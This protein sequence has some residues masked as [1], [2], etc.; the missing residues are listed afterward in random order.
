MDLQPFPEIA[1]L[2]ANATTSVIMAIDFND[3]TQPAEFVIV[4]NS[5]S[6][7]VKVSAPVGE[8]LQPNTITEKDFISRKSKTRLLTFHSVHQSYNTTFLDKLGG[9]NEN[10]ALVKVSESPEQAIAKAIQLSSNVLQVSASEL[11]VFYFAGKTAATSVDVLVTC[12]I[13]EEQVK[14]VV[15]CEKMVIGSMLLRDIKQFLLNASK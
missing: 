8:L 14:V 11:N 7:P 12:K 5:K 13:V 1:S 4:T 9:M 3:T 6:F 10:S 15:N 2:S